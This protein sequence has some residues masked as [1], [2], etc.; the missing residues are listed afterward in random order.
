MW[1]T[2]YASAIPKDLGVGVDFRPCSEGDFLSGRP[3]SVHTFI[4]I[5]FFGQVLGF[6]AV[7]LI[8]YQNNVLDNT[9]KLI[10]QRY[11]M[12]G[13]GTVCK[14]FYCKSIFSNFPRNS[15]IKYVCCYPMQNKTC[16]D[17]FIFFDLFYFSHQS[18]TDL[19]IIYEAKNVSILLI[20]GTHLKVHKQQNTSK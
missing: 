4:T 1:Q 17:N 9:S 8:F 18:T 11:E 2:K 10:V 20:C 3:Q 6:F 15:I 7:F 16:N 5:S 19:D 12:A 13:I 14:M